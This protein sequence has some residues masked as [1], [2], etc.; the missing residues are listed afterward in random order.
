MLW[1]GQ[2]FHRT[3][4]KLI[5]AENFERP[6]QLLWSLV[7]NSLIMA[8]QYITVYDFFFNILKSAK[9]IGERKRKT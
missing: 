8:G 2:L 3:E 4:E 9:N 7:K 6:A 5:M 1:I